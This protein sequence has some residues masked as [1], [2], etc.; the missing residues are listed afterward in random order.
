MT[1]HEARTPTGATGTFERSRVVLGSALR[2]SWVPLAAAT[3]SLILSLAS[4]WISTRQPDVLLIMPDLV[5]VAEGRA[6]G[7]SYIYVQPAFVSTGNNDR[8]EVIRDMH[9]RVQPS[10]G[11]AVDLSWDEQ[12]RLVQDPATKVLSYEYQADAVPLLISPKS[13]AAPL[14][15]FQAPDG[16]YF[17]PGTYRFTLTA[18]R[19]VASDPLTASFTVTLAQADI[20]RLS[21]PGQDTFLA[22]PIR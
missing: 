3:L 22:F 7:A 13:A 8:V 2:L 10:S 20:D 17:G 21:A 15:L 5:R 19:T 14:S 12:V 9:V 4:I 18:E 16:W 11:N 6:S 1:E